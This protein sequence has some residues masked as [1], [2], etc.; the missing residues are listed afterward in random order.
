MEKNLTKGQ[1]AWSSNTL[2]HEM[3]LLGVVVWGAGAGGR[4]VHLTKGQPDP[5]ADQMSS[6]PKLVSLLATRC[7]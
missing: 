1:P 5:K 2:G 4:E 3:S 6:W 7:L